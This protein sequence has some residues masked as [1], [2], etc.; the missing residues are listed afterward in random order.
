MKFTGANARQEY[1]ASKILA[2]RATLEWTAKEKPHFNV[3]TLHPAF[4]FGRNLTQTSS[5]AL[6]GTNAMLWASLHSEKPSIPMSAVD[7]RDVA[8]AHVKALQTIFETTA[9]V[10]EFLL[11]AS[12]A[13]G[14]TWGGVASFVRERY[15]T[16]KIKLNGKFNAPPV[17]E[18]ERA[19][20]LLGLQWR[21]ME[22]TI[23]SFLDHQLELRHR[24]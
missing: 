9:Q 3:I 7:V 13:D 4:V 18:T 10:E 23:S 17:I 20:K 21:K 12:E 14:W 1:Q 2:H 15:P 22:D 5:D 11:S 8:S 24:L 19:E 6:D 16:L